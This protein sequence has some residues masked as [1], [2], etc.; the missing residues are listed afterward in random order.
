MPQEDL[1]FQRESYL[2]KCSHAVYVPG[3]GCDDAI[4]PKS[5]GQLVVELFNGAR[6]TMSIAAK[7]QQ[8]VTIERILDYIRDSVSE[9]TIGREHLTNKRDILN[10]KTNLT[11]RNTRK[12]CSSGLMQSRKNNHLILLNNEGLEGDH[13]IIGIRM[14]LC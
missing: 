2:Q 13:G 1:L 8:G 6:V 9:Q 4:P 14:I 7:I 10:V 3:I 12:T 11:S 5:V